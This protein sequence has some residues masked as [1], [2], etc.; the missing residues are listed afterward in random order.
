MFVLSNEVSNVENTN[1]N[2]AIDISLRFCKVYEAI[3][4]KP[5]STIL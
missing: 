1:T 4:D 3:S 5:L 2:T